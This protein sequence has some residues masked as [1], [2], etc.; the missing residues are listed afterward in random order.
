MNAK[1]VSKAFP[2]FYSPYH[3]YRSTYKYIDCGPSVGMTINGEDLYCDQLP[4]KW[5]G[6]ITRIMVS[7]IVEGVDYG[8]D[9]ETVVIDPSYPVTEHWQAELCT[10]I[11]ASKLGVKF[12]GARKNSK[13]R[14]RFPETDRYELPDHVV[15]YLHLRKQGSVWYCPC[16]KN[17]KN[18]Q[19][20]AKNVKVQR[21]SNT[22][23]VKFLFSV[24]GFKKAKQL[25]VQQI[26]EQYWQAVVQIND[27][28]KAIW[29]ETHGCDHCND[30]EDPDGFK[31][32]NPDCKVC[33]GKG[34]I[35]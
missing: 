33:H 6:N 23:R 9:T 19:Q 15:S 8:T 26:K 24:P 5:H 18:F 20:K 28:A 10:W 12:D 17:L 21:G 13:G 7:S 16:F 32:I 31:P 34:V 2:D 3:L 30:F 35:I 29:D 25:S 14:W 11:G 27:Q 22:S 4:D 1:K